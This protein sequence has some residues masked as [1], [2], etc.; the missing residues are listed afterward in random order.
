MFSIFN[1][2]SVAHDTLASALTKK[3]HN[4]DFSN[5]TLHK[6]IAITNKQLGISKGELH[7][8]M[9]NNKNIAFSEKSYNL[10][11]QLKAISYQII[12]PAIESKIQSWIQQCEM[13][14]FPRVQ[15]KDTSRK[16]SPSFTEFTEANY[17][18]IGEIL[19]QGGEAIVVSDKKN[20][21]L[22]FKIFFDESKIHEIHEQANSFNRFYGQKSAIIIEN[23]AILMKRVE[24]IPL[25]EVPTFKPEAPLKLLELIKQMKE[26]GC[27]PTDLSENNFLYDIKSGNFFPVDIGKKSDNQ[28]DLNGVKHLLNFINERL[29]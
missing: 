14:I 29:S 9:I 7:N 16:N 1:H 6:L 28:T 2:I 24:G 21:H 3:A 11:N 13:P 5:K 12:S 26:K 25:S 15:L 18:R 17:Q 8:L 27:P 10:A 19:G 20:P 22:A 23:R 4:K